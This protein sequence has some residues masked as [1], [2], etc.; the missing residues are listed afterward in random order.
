MLGSGA[1]MEYRLGLHAVCAVLRSSLRRILRPAELLQRNKGSVRLALGYGFRPF[2]FGIRTRW[3]KI[4][5]QPGTGP[6]AVKVVAVISPTRTRACEARSVT[7]SESCERLSSDLCALSAGD[8]R[9][10]E[11]HHTEMRVSATAHRTAPAQSTEPGRTIPSHRSTTKT[12]GRVWNRS[13][14]GW[15]RR[16]SV[17]INGLTLPICLLKSCHTRN[18]PVL[19]TRVLTP[20]HFATG[21][22]SIFRK[23]REIAASRPFTVF[24][25]PLGTT[26][27][28]HSNRCCKRAPRGHPA[29]C[30]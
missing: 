8:S 5:P 15:G 16:F 2:A 11:V 10:L 27:P 18:T 17:I 13:Y 4:R 20:L 14:D 25:S 19:A 24:R 7:S 29:K 22:H 21:S 26:A 9:L 23:L 28:G 6:R 3:R 12:G 1:G 30:E